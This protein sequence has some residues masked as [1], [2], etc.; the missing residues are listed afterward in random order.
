[1]GADILTSLNINCFETLATGRSW[2]EN[3]SIRHGKEE[4]YEDE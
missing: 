3:R 4:K 1:M 2:P